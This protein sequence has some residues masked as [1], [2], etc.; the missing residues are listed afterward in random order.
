L[1]SGFIVTRDYLLIVAVYFMKMLASV[2]IHSISQKFFLPVQGEILGWTVNYIFQYFA[3][4][5][6]KN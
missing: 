2:I 3:Y 1:L 4:C 5:F 6:W